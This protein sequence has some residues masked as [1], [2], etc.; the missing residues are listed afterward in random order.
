VNLEWA[1]KKTEMR[2]MKIMEELPENLVS[3]VRGCERYLVSSVIYDHPAP[4]SLSSLAKVL[5]EIPDV[6]LLEVMGP[7]DNPHTL[8]VSMTPD[9]AK[10]LKKQFQG[11][12]IFEED[13]MLSQFNQ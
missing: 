10:Q 2:G 4:T 12:F 9:R 13:S 6:E 1:G 7:Q 3:S 5:K 8:L 11:Q